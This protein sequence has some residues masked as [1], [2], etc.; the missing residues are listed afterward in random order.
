MF[1]CLNIKRLYNCKSL[2]TGMRPKKF[3]TIFFSTGIL[4]NKFGTKG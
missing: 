3:G 1:K 2:P 4:Q